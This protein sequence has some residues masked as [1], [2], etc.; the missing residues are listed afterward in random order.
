M[1]KVAVAILN[2]NGKNHLER[3]LPS[4]YAHTPKHVPVFVIDN[5]STDD[6]IDFLKRNYPQI[7][8][9]QNK[10]NGGFALGYN[11]GLKHIKADYFILLNSDVEV[12]QNW[13][14]PIVDLMDS[15]P[16]I[17]GCQ[18]KIK[19]FTNKSFFEHAG[20]CGGYID[21]FGYPFCRGR[22]LHVNE[23][24]EGQYDEIKEIFWAS[25]ACMFIRSDCFW[26][27]KGF[28][29]DFFAHM[30]EID[31]CWRLK[32][33]GYKFYAQPASEVFHLGGGTLQY[34]SP[35]KTYLNF[36]NSLFTIYKNSS[37]ENL[38]LIILG[39]LLIDGI[40]ALRMLA[41]GKMNH[42]KALFLAHMNFYKNLPQLKEKR[43]QNLTGSNLYGLYNGSIILNFYLKGCKKFKC[44]K[45]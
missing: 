20:A 29:E 14:E 35:R 22:I 7:N 38:F 3:F 2:W 1:S 6:S 32:N 28:D 43:K 16:M 5:A 34:Q 33:S 21:I 13:I 4:V 25:G 37:S 44:F 24:D 11:E 39:R 27:A 42:V 18:P 31:L 23:M 19:S 12:S 17:A 26:K 9:I 30:E 41:G 8:I 45:F 36:R 40:A 10:T 15:D